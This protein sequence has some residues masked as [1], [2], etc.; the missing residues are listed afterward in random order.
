VPPAR[1]ERPDRIRIGSSVVVLEQAWLLAGAEGRLVI[2]DG[3]R[4]GRFNTLSCRT[5]LILESDVSGSDG[6]CIFD[7][8]PIETAPVVVETGAYLGLNAVVYPGVRI[9]RGAFVGE[10]AVVTADVPARSVVYGNPARVVRRFDERSRSWEGP[11][12]P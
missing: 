11:D 4:L 9:G 2:G 1:V 10:G 12:R 7:T 6:V 8:W 5:G 3:V